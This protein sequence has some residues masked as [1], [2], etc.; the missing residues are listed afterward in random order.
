MDD[1]IRYKYDL[2]LRTINDFFKKHKNS[3]K[4]EHKFY[5]QTIKERF[6]LK[7]NILE[8]NKSKL[9]QVKNISYLY[10]QLAEITFEVLTYF[11][12]HQ[13]E[14]L[15]A[16]KVKQKIVSKYL[17]KSRY[18][19]K[20]KDICSKKV[21]KLFQKKDEKNLYFSLLVLLGIESYFENSEYKKIIKL[22]N[23]HALFFSPEKL[24][25][26]MVYDSLVA[27][28]LYEEVLKEGRDMTKKQFYLKSKEHTVNFSSNPDFLVKKEGVWY[29]V[30]AKWKI[31]DTPKE[32]DILKLS[33][34]AKVRGFNQGLLI[35][36]QQ[37][38][39]SK[40]QLDKSYS[41]DYDDGFLFALQ[42][43]N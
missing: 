6:D 32:E 34:D 25:E 31:L 3:L 42:V 2:A 8:M 13:K 16:K 40:Y 29:V 41:Y 43:L 7:A 35:Y 38:K 5:A 28:G 1:F 36:P 14:H 12:R 27:S 4:K 37:S 26:W 30:D 10:S 22:H 18:T 20:T 24:F 9:H 17:L 39:E 19:F 21:L 15:K 23:Q 11:I 33:R